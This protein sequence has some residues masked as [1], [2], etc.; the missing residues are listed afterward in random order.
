MKNETVTIAY[1]GNAMDNRFN[2]HVVSKEIAKKNGEVWTP[3]ELVETMMSKIPEEDWKNPEKTFLEPTMGSG[4][5]VICMLEKRIASG[6]NPVQAL[7]TLF[8][9]EL[10][11]DNVDICK[12]RIRDVLRSNKVKI[13]E[14]IN[15]IIDHNFVCSDFF[16]WDFENWRPKEESEGL[17]GMDEFLIYNR[18]ILPF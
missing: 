5:M 7:K 4:N 8:G 3:R 2:E 13:T 14:K 11:Q 10:M 1:L 9:V 6:V 16:N 15:E 18:P 17:S 12:D